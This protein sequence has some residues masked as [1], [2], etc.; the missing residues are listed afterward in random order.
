MSLIREN[1]AV[2]KTLK[3]A[4]TGDILTS[5][6]QTCRLNGVDAWDYP[7]DNNQG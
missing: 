4:E 2:Y 1:C 6:I 7:G 5:L 3:G